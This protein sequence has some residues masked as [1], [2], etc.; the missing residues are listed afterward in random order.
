[1]PKRPH[2]IIL[3]PDE[4][5]ASAVHHLGCEAASTPNLDA[6]AANEAVSFS[7]AYCQNPVCV[8]SRC[9]FFTGLYPHVM[10]HRTMY[11]ML[12]GREESLFSELKKA[13]YYVWMN[14][15]NDFLAGQIPELQDMHADEIFRQD[16]SYRHQMKKPEEMTEAEKKVLSMMARYPYAHYLGV[17]DPNPMERMDLTSTEAACRRI[18]TPVPEDKP[19]CL[20]VG[21]VN[22]HPTYMT[23][24]DH[25]NRIDPAKMV[26]RIRAEECSGKSLMLDKLREYEGLDEFPDELW[27]DMGRVYLAQTALIDDMFGMVCDA[28]KEAGMYDDS[29]IFVL[30]DHG[31][32]AGDYN[33]PEK[34]QNTFEDCLV[35]VPLLIKP[36]K[37]CPVDP[38]V[39]DSIT[40]LIDFYASVMDYAGVKPLHDQFG[41]SLRPVV[42]NRETPNRK[43]AFSEGGR[44]A[45]EEQCDEF[46]QAGPDGPPKANPYWAKMMAEKDDDAHEKGTMICDGRFKYVLRLSGKDEFYDLVKD[47]GERI[48]EIGNPDYQEKILEMKL[49]MLSW[50]QETCDTVPREYDQ[51]NFVNRE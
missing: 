46:H 32:F 25:Y 16:I 21:W 29:A 23:D 22:P 51:R 39:T 48:N 6:F 24:Q 9:S 13:G 20:F 33:L 36:P 8:P 35:R 7:Q 42:E 31:D 38:G 28:L 44:R 41:R 18:L 30:S 14:D 12:R 27:D 3:N 15:R 5:R 43:Y 17:V 50:Y 47:P 10:G 40:E 1:M 11:H 49:A 34:T 19:L 45:S 37:D 26:P 2:I 4:L